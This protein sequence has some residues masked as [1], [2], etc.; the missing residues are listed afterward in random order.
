MTIRGRRNGQLLSR[1]VAGLV[2]LFA[3]GCAGPVE[4]ST[5]AD[6]RRIDGELAE[7]P[8]SI[9]PPEQPAA[10]FDGSLRGYLAFAFAHRPRLRASFEDWRAAS[11]RPRQE[12]RLPEPTITY[13]GFVSSVE[14]RVG[15]QQH[16]LGAMQWFPWP[17]KLAAGGKA[18]SLEARAAQRRFEAEALDIAAEVSAAY[19]AVWRVERQR[20]VLR[21][22]VQ[23][24]TSLSE[25]VRVRVEVG[26]AD[27]ADLAQID[28]MVSRTQDR[29]AGLDEAER[30]A[31]ARLVYVL[32]APDGVETPVSKNSPAVAELDESIATLTAEAA[33]HPRVS[34]LATLSDATGER[35][36]EARA[37][38]FP[39]FG[40]GVDW[41]ITGR[42]RAAMPPPDSGKDAVA[43]ALSL[44]IPLWGRAY[45]AA[46]DEARAK[47]AALRA[48]A[49]EARNGIA[50]GVRQQAARL[51]D[52]V[53]R[54]RAYKT[55]LVPQAETTFESVL[56]SYATGRSSV[57]ELLLAERELIG[58]QDEL[59]AAEGDYGVHVAE[60]ERTV[61]RPVR[62]KGPSDER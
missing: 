17:S 37:D 58:L 44:K 22:E 60:L 23:I 51:N 45:R 7:L 33:A 36:R 30:I 40:V 19:W 50:A 41:I 52:D 28:L 10:E 49:I 55:T 2:L 9:E 15:P 39:S 43:L 6:L 27:L 61:G 38:R 59:Y 21:E 26:G 25:Q 29:L 42:S 24:L 35:V 12:R 13:A 18:A 14:T 47:G 53:R 54:V 11:H 56:N 5:R 3:A 32:G 16:K 31:K 57:A 1:H 46:E 20:E 48:R 62:T 34:T 4:R 8:A